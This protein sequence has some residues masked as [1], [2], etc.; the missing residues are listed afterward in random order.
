[1]TMIK[2]NEFSWVVELLVFVFGFME[3]Q[4]GVIMGCELSFCL[5]L[6]RIP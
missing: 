5:A 1:M 6:G 2:K 3:I 4:M